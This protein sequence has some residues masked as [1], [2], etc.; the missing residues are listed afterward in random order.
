LFGSATPFTPAVL[1]QLYPTHGD[2]VSKVK[3]SAVMT[4]AAGFI[5]PQE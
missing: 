5:L 1:K 3:T 2:Y 4:R